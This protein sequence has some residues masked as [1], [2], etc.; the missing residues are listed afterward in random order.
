LLQGSFSLE[1]IEIMWME[2]NMHVA[3]PDCNPYINPDFY[4]LYFQVFISFR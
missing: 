4:L 3:N 2:T 1:K